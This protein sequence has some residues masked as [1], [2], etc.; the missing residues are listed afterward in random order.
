[1]R[2]SLKTRES[3]LD[4][5]KDQYDDES[6]E[7]FVYYYRPFIYNVVRSMNINH[8]DA[9]EI[10]QTVVIKAWNKLPSF[11]YDKLKG[12]F[13]SWLGQVTANTIRDFIR[14]YKTLNQHVTSDQNFTNIEQMCQNLPEVQHI[15]EKEWKR[16]ISN[17]AW[18]T[19]SKKFKKHVADTFLMCADRVPTH[20]I[21]EKLGISES[22]VYVYK[23]RVQKR[24]RDEIIRLNRLL[25]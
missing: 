13:R 4:R 23:S 19:V 8:H 17:L 14:K 20:T 2:S 24:L 7:E 25:H 9:E 12:K 1:M 16:Y 11:R 3:L 22:S 10:V 6:W 15:A 21:V 18:E 5:I